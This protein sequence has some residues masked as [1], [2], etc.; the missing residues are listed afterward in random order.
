MNG[1]NF[2]KKLEDGKY[3][4]HGSN[5]KINALEPRQAYDWSSGKKQKDGTPAVFATDNLDRAIFMALL[6]DI[7]GMH[8][9]EYR[10]GKYI[11]H[12]NKRKEEELSKISNINGFVMVLPRDKFKKSGADYRAETEIKPD[13]IIKVTKKDLPSNIEVRP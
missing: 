2:L 12:I 13:F 4:F 7:P 10:V 9:S 8:G 3:L 5:K 1:R 11:L 6:R